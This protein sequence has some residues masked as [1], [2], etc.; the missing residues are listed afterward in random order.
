MEFSFSLSSSR[1]VPTVIPPQAVSDRSIIDSV[2]GFIN[3]VGLNG[4]P[5]GDAKEQIIWSRFETD[6]DIS[7]LSF[8]EDWDLEEGVAP[9]P[10]ILTLGY[11]TGIQMWAIPANGEAI[12]VLSWRHGGPV[13]CLKILPTPLMEYGDQAGPSV[14]IYHAKRPLIAIS[15]S[16]AA[17]VVNFV[18]LRDGDTVKSIKFKHPLVEILAN[19]TTVVITFQERIAVF[20]ARTFEDRC[21]VT[22]CF[23]SPGL[24]PNPVALG[25][26]WLA[27][28]ELKVMPSKRSHGGC[29][30]L[31]NTST[32]ASVIS[33]AKSLG[34]GLKGIGETIGLSTGSG[35]AGAH[36]ATHGH[37][38][39]SASNAQYG[40]G[41]MGG[42]GVGHAGLARTGS[43]GGLSPSGSQ[44]GL[45]ASDGRQPGLITVMD[46][47]YAIKDFSPTS[48]TPVSVKGTDPMVAHFV[49]HQDA[50]VNVAFDPSGMLLLTADKRGHDFNLFRIYPHPGGPSLAAVHHLYVLHRGDTTAKVQD[51]SFSMDSR[52]VAVSSLRGT[53]HVFPITPYGGNVCIR[54]HG[55]AQVVNQLS[56]FH[57]SA[58]LSMDGR[59]SSPVT[60]SGEGGSFGSHAGALVGAL[61]GAGGGGG[62]SGGSGGACGSSGGTGGCGSGS[63][64]H[65]QNL[66]N[67]YA[68]PRVPPFAHPT[69]VLPLTQLRQPYAINSGT[70]AAPSPHVKDYLFNVTLGRQ[71]HSSLSD[72]TMMGGAGGSQAHPL[73]ICAT[74]ARPRAWLLDPP[75]MVRD[76]PAMRMNKTVMDSLFIMASH[77]AM[78]QYDLE[79]RHSTSKW[80]EG[81]NGDLSLHV[82]FFF[83]FSSRCR[84]GEGLR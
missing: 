6:A 64:G 78:I 37:G 34:K 50:I 38:G 1:C 43:A 24:N 75:G 54:T 10:L 66:S 7:D 19:R 16:A 62:G 20:D 14:D 67:A 65:Y 5:P 63:N 27:Y 59:C 2:T 33:A 49:A 47:K 52:W 4:A 45:N 39:V 8:G 9:P 61:A 84:P 35:G 81:E 77:G 42:G 31:V 82:S 71:R 58:G 21:T 17:N 73:R 79:P 28:A 13:K 36:A 51:I 23:P 3:E 40:G 32:M 55:S 74:F 30:S 41:G 70:Q 72:D 11:C 76:G 56:R 12:E 44:Q 68:N 26:R 48:G 46:I 69:M 53:T 29:D 25:A 22:T 60:H 57:R 18:S 83:F 80:G 15:D